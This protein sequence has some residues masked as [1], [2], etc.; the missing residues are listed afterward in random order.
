MERRKL[1]SALLLISTFT[2]LECKVPIVGKVYNIKKFLWTT[3]PIWTYSTTSRSDCMCQ[4]DVM[5]HES[6][7]D[8][9]FTHIFYDEDH[10]RKYIT[11]DGVLDKKD[12]V[13]VH[14][15]GSA[16]Y[17]IKE[18]IEYLNKSSKCAVI[19]VLSMSS[20]YGHVNKYDLRVWNSSN[21][22]H[23][24]QPCLHAFKKLPV[25]GLIIYKP[26]CHKILR[27]TSPQ[28]DA[29]GKQSQMQFSC[30]RKS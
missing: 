10:H 25:P 15:Y 26:M 28:L 2:V 6:A 20:F 4:V 8:I 11:L 17:K 22:A 27:E 18:E 21:I 24:A 16:H 9:T 14:P 5:K 23:S 3:T 13:Y 7:K 29:K 19:H 12:V 1:F 30:S